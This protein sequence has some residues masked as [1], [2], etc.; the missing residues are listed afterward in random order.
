[1]KRKR[2]DLTLW[3]AAHVHKH[4]SMWYWWEYIRR[5]D[6]VNHEKTDCDVIQLLQSASV[7]KQKTQSDKFLTSFS[8]GIRPTK[9]QKRVLN[10]MLRVS[11]YTYNWCLW[12]VNEKGIGPHQFELQKIVCKTN[13]ND[14]DPQYR[15]ENDDWFFNNRMTSV[16]TTSCKN[17]YTSY[18]AAKSLKSK[19]KR[20]MSVSNIVQG[21]FCVPKLFIR[22]LSSKDVSIDNINMLNRYIC[23]IPENFEKRSKPKERFLKL[24]KP[25]TKIPPF[26]HDVKIVKRANGTFVMNIPCDPKYTRRN[27][28]NDTIDKRVCGIDPGGRTFATVYDPIDCCVFQVGIKE[29][30]QYVISKLHNK[31]DHAHMHLTKAQN[32]KQQQ[33]ASERIVSLK[34]THLKLKTFVEDIHLKLSS[35]LVKEYQYVA[36]GKINVAPL[37]KKKH[38]SKRAKRDLLY[39]QHYRFRQRL[40]HRTTNTDCIFE[41]QNEAYTSMTCGVCGKLNKNLEKSETF[42]CDSCNYNTHRDVNGARNILLKSLNMFPFEKKQQ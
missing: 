36:L 30:K 42:Y 40:T 15:M 22:N 3:D 39:W 32:K 37:V 6:M 1:M 7:K 13:A 41:V 17:F 24:A 11:N 31:I 21:S 33:A 20:P 16:K 18:K 35:H 14:V 19:L 2:E 12:L 9:H 25:I 8:V 10:E 27:A 4:K 26:D 23:M 5:K 29:D 28:S 38:L 34:K